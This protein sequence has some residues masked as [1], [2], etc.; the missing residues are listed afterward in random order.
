MK[1]DLFEITTE[2]MTWGQRTWRVALLLAIIA[3]CLLD[4]LVWRP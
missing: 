3:V 2:G 4:L 1:Y